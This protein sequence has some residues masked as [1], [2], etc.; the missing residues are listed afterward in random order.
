M[1]RVF[2]NFLH[3]TNTSKK[4]KTKCKALFKVLSRFGDCQDI[5]IRIIDVKNKV[6]KVR[7]Q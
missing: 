1:F 4:N 5:C 2:N 3:F 7:N 6:V